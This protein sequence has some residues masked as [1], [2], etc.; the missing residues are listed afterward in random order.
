MIQPLNWHFHDHLHF[1]H[2]LKQKLFDHHNFYDE[3]Y[4]YMNYLG[5][6]DYYWF[7]SVY[8]SVSFDVIAIFIRDSLI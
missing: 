2:F 1:L 6:R 3:Y 5:Y 8:Y 4:A 7:N